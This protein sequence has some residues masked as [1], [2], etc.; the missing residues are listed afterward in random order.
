MVEHVEVARKAWTGERFSHHG[1]VLDV[2]DLLVRPAPA[3]PPQLW[4]G[5]WVDAAIRRA[6]RIGDGYVS[7]STG[8][9]D[10]A[11]RIEVL[12]Q[13]AARVG[14]T[15]PVPVSAFT[16][17]AFDDGA[18]I[19]A[20]VRAGVGHLHDGYR[21]WY[22]SSSDWGGGREFGEKLASFSDGTG[23][24][25]SGTSEQLLDRLGTLGATFARSRPFELG[26]RLHYPGMERAEVLDAM[27]RFAAEV[28]TP[29]RAI[30]A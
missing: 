4:I 10:T 28:L 9:R 27:A 23:W 17:S 19:T 7:P 20:A 12:D 3:R 22:S 14:R 30:A 29:L 1:P 2:T 15:E 11:R 24:I 5:G 13:E 16:W 26:V 18:G 21:E 25:Q 6:A 8:V